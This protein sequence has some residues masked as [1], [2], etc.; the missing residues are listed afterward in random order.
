MFAAHFDSGV[1]FVTGWVGLLA[2]SFHDNYE[3]TTLLCRETCIKMRHLGL[4]KVW[5]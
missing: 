5:L 4:I 1:S 3:F 2:E